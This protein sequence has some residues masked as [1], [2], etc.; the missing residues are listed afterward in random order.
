MN[1]AQPAL[2]EDLGD[3]R[4]PADRH[5]MHARAQLADLADDARGDLDAFCRLAIGPGRF[6]LVD[7]CLRHAIP[8]T[9]PF[10]QTAI[11]A[12][13]RN[14]AGEQRRVAELAASRN[15]ASTSVS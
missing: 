2:R 10:S 14:D 11:F 6:H 8:G 4:F 12:I 9:L 7:Q 3:P 1:S 13:Q 5:D 15:R